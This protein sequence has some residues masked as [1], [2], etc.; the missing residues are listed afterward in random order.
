MLTLKSGSA[1]DVCAEEYGPQCLPHSIPCGHVLC[2]S[3][4]NTI[5]EKTTARLSPAC[6]FCRES[7]TPDSVRLIRMDFTTSGWSTPRRLPQFEPGSDFTGELLAKRTEQLLRFDP[8]PRS[9]SETRRLEDK[10]ARIAA[11]KCSVEEVSALQKELEGWLK[12]GRDEQS[13]SLFLSAALLRAILMNHLAHSEASRV[14]KNNE[15]SLKSKIEHLE[16]TN[17]NWETQYNRQKKIHEQKSQE[18]QQLR[19]EVT[20]LRSLATSLGA[21]LPP[22]T[23]TSSISTSNETTPPA[24][25]RATSPSTYTSPTS[26]PLSPSRY[27]ALHSRS[28]S[29][30]SSARPIT[31]A[32]PS[33]LSRSQTP[34][35]SMLSHSSSIRS[36]TP[37]V[38]SMTPAVGMGRSYTPAP[39]SSRS[40]TPGPGTHYTSA[41]AYASRSQTPAPSSTHSHS[42]TYNSTAPPPP[43]PP[44]PRRLSQSSPPQMMAR[45]TSEEKADARQRWIP[46]D[47]RVLVETDV[48]SY[49]QKMHG[50]AARPVG[51]TART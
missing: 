5:V 51:V 24:S 26:S 48:G 13:S 42:H 1:C 11:K 15:V 49:Y 21:S 23:T 40:M 27:H 18:C 46:P 32:T 45:S 43:I 16:L 2:A 47:G 9:K 34:G 31:P 28:M 33:P 8:D 35:P 39:V 19:A 17:Q 3:C 14:A 4:C 20:Q 38:R 25:P 22:T 12:S 36:A 30:S 7:F 29:T 37:S 41:S 6:P 44:K 10:V 50:N